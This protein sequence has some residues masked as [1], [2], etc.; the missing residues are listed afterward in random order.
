[1]LRVHMETAGLDAC[2]FMSYHNVFYFSDFL[3]CKFGRNYGYIM[4]PEKAISIS[5]CKYI[6]TG[7]GGA[8]LLFP[9]SE[10]TS[11]MKL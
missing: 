5:A 7:G 10:R 4:T 3:Y 8:S 11:D 1:M 2:V 9:F 6:Y